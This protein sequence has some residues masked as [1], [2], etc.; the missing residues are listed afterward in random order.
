MTAWSHQTLHT[1]ISD[2]GA[3]LVTLAAVRGSAPREAGTQMLIGQTRQYGSIGGGALEYQACERARTMLRNGEDLFLE[4]CTLGPDLGQC[5]GGSVDLRYQRLHGSAQEIIDR[6][7]PP[8]SALT[9]LYI[10]GAGHVGKALVHVLD[11]LPFAVHW[12][13]QR[14]QSFAHKVRAGVNLHRGDPAAL[15]AMAPK[16]AFYC[17]LTHDHTLDYEIIRAVL[18]RGDAGFAGLIGSQTKRARFIQ[19]LKKEG[20]DEDQLARLTCP[21]GL[22]SIPGKAPEAIAIAIAAQMLTLIKTD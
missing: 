22:S 21:I 1:I 3:V 7:M 17:V 8:A 14:P 6:L 12:A 13:D 9:P 2:D 20:L 15:V 4:T 16:G 10:F 18:A 5:C 11:G 19:R